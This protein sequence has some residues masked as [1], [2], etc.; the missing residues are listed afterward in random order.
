VPRE[1]INEAG[2]GMLQ[3][4]IDYALPLI[5]GTPDD[6]TENGMPRYPKLRWIPA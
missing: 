4:Y 6:K 1:W 3:P 5:Q 2:N